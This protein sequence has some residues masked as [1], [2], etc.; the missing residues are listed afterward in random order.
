MI[1]VLLWTLAVIYRFII[2]ENTQSKDTYL[3]AIKSDPL[4]R[5]YK[6]KVTVKIGKETNE[7]FI[8]NKIIG[9]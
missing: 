9:H 2:C 4:I 3:E 7:E 8:N 5:V 1:K 6:K